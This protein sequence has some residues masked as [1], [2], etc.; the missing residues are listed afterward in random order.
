[1]LDP[2]DLSGNWKHQ[3]INLPNGPNIV[4]FFSIAYKY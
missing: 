4:V 1:M 2:S 3:V